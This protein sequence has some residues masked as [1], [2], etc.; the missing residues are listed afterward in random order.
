M[1]RSKTAEIISKIVKRLT[2]WNVIIIITIKLFFHHLQCLNARINGLLFYNLSIIGRNAQ[3]LLIFIARVD[4][5]KAKINEYFILKCLLQVKWEIMPC[6]LLLD[7]H[8]ALTFPLHL[9]QAWSCHVCTIFHL[10]KQQIYHDWIL[11]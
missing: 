1:L 8:Q 11:E 4:Q 9:K 3:L 5:K 2:K 7:L 10:M 6:Y